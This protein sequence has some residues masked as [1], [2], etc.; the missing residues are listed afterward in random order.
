MQDGYTHWGQQLFYLMEPIECT[1]DTIITG[2]GNCNAHKPAFARHLIWPL[3]VSLFRQ[4]KN[5]RLYEVEFSVSVNG[6]K[7]TVYKYEMP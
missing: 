6:A 7:P 2:T 1:Q 5:Q 3:A 4:V